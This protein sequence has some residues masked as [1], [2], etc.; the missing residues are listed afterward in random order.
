[1]AGDIITPRGAELIKKFLLGGA[2]LGGGTALG[3]DLINYM[4]HLNKN[5]EEADDDTLYVYKDRE[6]VKAAGVNTGSAFAGGVLSALGAGAA[7]HKLYGAF[8]KRE[9]Q[10]ELDKAQ[11]AFLG[12][13]GYKKLDKKDKKKSDKEKEESEKKAAAEGKMPG[14]TETVT[15]LPTTAAILLALASG[16]TSYAMLNN[17]FPARKPK[18][19]GPRKIEIVEK[20]EDDQSEYADKSAS[21]DDARELVIRTL[22]VTK[23]AN[24]SDIR[25]LVAAV[26]AGE[27]EM[28]KSAAAATGFVPALDTVKGAADY[29]T[30]SPLEELLA[31]SYVAK[32]ASTQ[33]LVDLVA[34]GEFATAFPDFY[35]TACCLDQDTR[36]T[37]V[38]I[39]CVMGSAIRAELAC[40]LGV[41]PTEGIQKE[42][43]MTDS[44][45]LNVTD[46]IG[47]ILAENRKAETD[48]SSD[49]STGTSGE[50]A[51]ISDPD[52]P[53]RANAANKTNFL[54]GGKTTKKSVGETTDDI[55]ELLM[56]SGSTASSDDE[57]DELEHSDQSLF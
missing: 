43:A 2:L 12:A 52:S 48:G 35:K 11:H 4:K 5:K 42:A 54:M 31:V 44:D 37:L 28:F 6:Q 55:D 49:E 21:W 3:V 45:H 14:L 17:Q 57:D 1:M 22:C 7:V 9:A 56:P 10:K 18:V 23:S 41:R 26:A 20:P 32:N 53:S 33:P 19:K 13:Q 40:E 50:E 46:I 24:V 8:R 38:K 39:A 29:R 16:A 36:D 27:G 47:K 51:G 30:V 25:N 34:A 15:S